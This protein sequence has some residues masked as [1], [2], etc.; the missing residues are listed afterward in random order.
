MWATAYNRIET[1][2]VLLEAGSDVGLTSGVMDVVK[3]SA[4]DRPARVQRQALVRAQRAA[5]LGP[6]AASEEAGRPQQQGAFPQRP[7]PAAQQPQEEEEE[8]SEVAQEEGETEDVVA[9]GEEAPE[10]DEAEADE[11]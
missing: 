11:P 2:R 7:A 9:G 10:A 8:P 1:M 5:A 4:L 6:E 3:V